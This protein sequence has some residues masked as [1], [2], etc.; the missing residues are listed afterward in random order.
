MKH[1]LFVVLEGGEGAGKT[2]QVDMLDEALRSRGHEVVKTREPG[3]TALGA[4]LRWLLLNPAAVVPARRA[5]A[6]MYAA[7]RAHHVEKVI[8]PA[9]LEGKVVLCDRYIGSSLAYQASAGGLDYDMVRRISLWA[10]DDL[11]P[12]LTFFLDLKPEVG[13]GR[14]KGR[15]DTNRFEDADLVFHHTVRQSFRHQAMSPD[16]M[17][18][19][20][21]HPV[22]VVHGQILDKVLEELSWYVKANKEDH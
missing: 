2:T 19:N 1:G 3:A 16:W 14:A 13:L 7:D 6:L 22:D 20:A 17:T 15:G 21:A 11:L 5:E 4:S 12:Q 18:V 9:L 8:R 10:A